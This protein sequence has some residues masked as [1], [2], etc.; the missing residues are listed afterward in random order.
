MSVRVPCTPGGRGSWIQQTALDGAVYQ[1]TFDWNG[2]VGLWMMHLADAQGV[3]IRTGMM[4]TT[5]TSLLRRIT[6]TRRP[7]GALV[8]VDL[9]GADD[10]D[11]GF[12][13]LGTRFV[14]SYITL[15]ELLA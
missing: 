6:D 5:G 11:P 2:R 3:A 4:L 10:A 14:L 9:T 15:A 7:P 8:V 13:D 12:D 1:F